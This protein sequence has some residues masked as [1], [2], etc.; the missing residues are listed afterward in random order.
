MTCIIHER[1]QLYKF[2]STD[3]LAWMY[4]LDR[5]YLYAPNKIYACIK[6][7][8]WYIRVENIWIILY[9]MLSIISLTRWHVYTH[10][11]IALPHLY[12]HKAITISLHL[13]PLF[14]VLQPLLLRNIVD[15][16]QTILI[17][18]STLFS[19]LFY[20]A[21]WQIVSDNNYCAAWSII[22]LCKFWVQQ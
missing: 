21:W 3:F 11:Y 5:A 9:A 16:C 19:Y 2:I 7:H 20:N 15:S 17:L 6:W 14:L 12:I 22:T 4:W 10:I 13:N 1:W 8:C 18:V